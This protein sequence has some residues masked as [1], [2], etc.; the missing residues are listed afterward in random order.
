LTKLDFGEPTIACDSCCA[1]GYCRRWNFGHRHRPYREYH[2]EISALVLALATV[3]AHASAHVGL[4][5]VVIHVAMDTNLYNQRPEWLSNA[6][7]DL[8]EAVF[9][10]YSWPVNLTQGDILGRLLELN[11]ERTAGLAAPAVP[12]K[13]A[14]N[15][16]K[17]GE[18]D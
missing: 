5:V 13:K 17:A 10:A 14:P 4:T 1:G 8:D 7:R 9:A 2:A 11:H 15:P 6:H 16:E 3:T 18:L 12:P